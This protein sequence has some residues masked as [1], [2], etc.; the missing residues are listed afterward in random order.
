MANLQEPFSKEWKVYDPS[1]LQEPLVM[2]GSSSIRFG[3]AVRFT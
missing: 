1:D 2:S 3:V